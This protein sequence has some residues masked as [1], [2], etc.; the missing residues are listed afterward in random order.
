[1]AIETKKLSYT[2][3]PSAIVDEGANIGCNTKIWHFSHI[4]SGAQIG[5][6]CTLGQNVYVAPSVKIGNHCRIQNNVSLFDGVFLEEKVFIG[7][8]VVFTNVS[9]PRAH[10]SQHNQFA[11]TS[12]K[13]GASIGAN[14]TIICGVTIGEWAMVGAGSTVTKN[15]LPFTLVVGNPARKV[16]YICKCGYDIKENE[17]CSICKLT[18][19]EVHEDPT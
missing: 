4:R 12:I 9:R 15:V 16:A 17:N 8:S 7:P 3:H 5:S 1:M 10:I 18:Y 11:T 19:K 13:K 14:A 2:I 6:E